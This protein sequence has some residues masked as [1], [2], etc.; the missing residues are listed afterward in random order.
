MKASQ[1]KKTVVKPASTTAAFETYDSLNF[2]GDETVLDEDY[3][4]KV[5]HTIPGHNEVCTSKKAALKDK[6]IVYTISEN[7][8]VCIQFNGKRI[9]K[10]DVRTTLKTELKKR[11]YTMEAG[12]CYSHGFKY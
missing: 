10:D 8:E 4:D 6:N 5:C 3:K 11:G 12:R 9:E 7:K 2:L 1:W